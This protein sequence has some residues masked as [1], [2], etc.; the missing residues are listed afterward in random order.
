[1]KN[2]KED[3]DIKDII[4]SIIPNTPE[5]E[6]AY[7]QRFT[8]MCL[9]SFSIRDIVVKEDKKSFGYVF[10]DIVQ[11]MKSNNLEEAR[12]LMANYIMELQMRRDS[13]PVYTP[14]KMTKKLKKLIGE[15]CEK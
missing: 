8:V 6:K 2:K 5:K 11:L 12:N 4:N 13:F 10:Y 14:I 3:I 1:M 9:K 15:K 7:L